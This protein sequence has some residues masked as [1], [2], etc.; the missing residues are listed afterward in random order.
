MG[1]RDTM[2]KGVDAV[3][4]GA[5]DVTIAWEG[6][7]RTG[8]PIR[9]DLKVTSTGNEVKT[10]GAFID[11]RGTAVGGAR[12]YDGGPDPAHGFG[13]PSIGASFAMLDPESK[14]FQIAD[15][16]VLG[17]DETLLFAGEI[18]LPVRFDDLTSWQIRGRVSTFGNDPDTGF[19]DFA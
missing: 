16:F 1:L 5:A 19:L 14:V 15:P 11:V 6:E 17:P 9:V 7:V 13:V 10:G 3:T 12:A 18:T 4:G 2:K 8:V